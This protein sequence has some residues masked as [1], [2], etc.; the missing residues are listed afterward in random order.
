MAIDIRI[1]SKRER[2][3]HIKANNFT[4]AFI[5]FIPVAIKLLFTWYFFPFCL[6]FILAL[7]SFSSLYDSAFIQ[8]WIV[9]LFA[10]SFVFTVFFSVSNENSLMKRYSRSNEPT[11][12]IA[13]EFMWESERERWERT[14]SLV[15]AFHK[16]L[17]SVLHRRSIKMWIFIECFLFLSCIVVVCSS[18][19]VSHMLNVTPIS[20][21]LCFNAI[22]NTIE[23]WP[24]CFAVN[25]DIINWWEQVYASVR[26]VSFELPF[27]VRFL[28][29]FSFWIH[30]IFFPIS[31]SSLYTLTRVCVCV[32]P[33][34]ISYIIYSWKRTR[35]IFFLSDIES[36]KIRAVR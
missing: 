1:A 27:F 14:C 19:G 4:W 28:S 5:A 32:R 35:S 30:R 8:L 16:M 12:E 34:F 29:V 13:F 24:F 36:N 33:F 17:I 7:T 11:N 2:S 9:Y 18:V 23:L 21:V 20:M 6:G 26:F 25:S 22:T 15:D 10:C 31:F 3:L